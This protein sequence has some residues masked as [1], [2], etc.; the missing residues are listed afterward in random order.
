MQDHAMHAVMLQYLFFRGVAYIRKKLRS[1]VLFVKQQSRV[2]EP[3]VCMAHAGPLPKSMTFSLAIT[4]EEIL[5]L[6][7]TAFF[8]RVGRFEPKK[9]RIPPTYVHWQMI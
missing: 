7:K 4:A 1:S 3:L 8:V 6:S 5:N 9:I 2:F